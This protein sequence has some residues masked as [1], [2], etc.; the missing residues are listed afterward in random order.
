MPS[1][2]AYTLPKSDLRCPRDTDFGYLQTWYDAVIPTAVDNDVKNDQLICESSD[3]N[4]AIVDRLVIDPLKVGYK[5]KKYSRLTPKLRTLMPKN[6]VQS[7]VQTLLCLSKR[8]ANA[9]VLRNEELSPVVAAMY[10]MKNFERSCLRD[11]FDLDTAFDTIEPNA[12][13]LQQWLDKQPPAVKKM[14]ESDVPLEERTYDRFAFMV[15]DKLKPPLE[16]S[17]AFKIPSGQTIAYH[18]KDVNAYVCPIFSVARDRLISILKPG[19]LIMTGMCNEE[20]EDRINDQYDVSGLWHTTNKIENDFSKYDKSQ[21]ETLLRFEILLYAKLGVPEELLDMWYR[22]HR[23]STLRDRSNGVS[24][25]TEFQRKSGDAVTFPG[26]HRVFA[27][28]YR[29][30]L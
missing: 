2:A 28:S 4:I 30:V 16:P 20:F 7:Q 12:A 3:L 27:G 14:I 13:L 17:A 6:V 15:K 21:H 5:D 22:S 9:P 8:N 10:L 18:T 11:D 1:V 23:R 29:C 26:E 24:M 19:I 25:G